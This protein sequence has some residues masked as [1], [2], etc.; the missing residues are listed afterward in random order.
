MELLYCPLACVRSARL[1]RSSSRIVIKGKL[2]TFNEQAFLSD[3]ADSNTHHISEIPDVELA[4]EYFT[5]PL[6]AITDKCA[7]FLKSLGL[8]IDQA[9]GCPQNYQ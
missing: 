8:K 5:N 2:K 6:L 9:P 4:L 1:E 7:S 3:L